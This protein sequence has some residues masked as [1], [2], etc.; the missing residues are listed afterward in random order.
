MGP[1][2]R[3]RGKHLIGAN[4]HVLNRSIPAHA[5]ETADGFTDVGMLRVH[6]RACG[7][8]GRQ[9]SMVS[10][11]TGSIPAHAGETLRHDQVGLQVRVHPRACGGND[12]WYP[13]GHRYRGPS[14]RMR[15]KRSLVPTRPPL[16]RSIPAHAGE[17]GKGRRI[18]SRSRVHPRA[19][20]G[21]IPA[22]DY[23]IIINGPSPRMRGKRIQALT[24]ASEYW[25][26]PAHAGETRGNPC[27]VPCSRVHPRA[28]GGNSGVVVQPRLT[29]GPSP[30]MRGKRRRSR[31][32][33]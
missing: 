8:N 1:S 11:D 23:W 7:G 33:A 2:P 30:R 4:S 10:I 28:C 31:G 13:L 20:G 6:P 12:R 18:P 24:L 26:I 32:S 17:T 14:P 25:S 16:P 9:K 22:D 15:G 5:G 19:C 21:N 27:P 29:K 3:M